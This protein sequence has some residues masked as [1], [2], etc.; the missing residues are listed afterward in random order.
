MFYVLGSSK[1]VFMMSSNVHMMRAGL[2]KISKIHLALAE[3]ERQC[4][5]V[6]C[7]IKSRMI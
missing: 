2:P 7:N 5:C 4:V 6:Q 1:E 3:R